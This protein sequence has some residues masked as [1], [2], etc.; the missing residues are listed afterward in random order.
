MDRL[1]EQWLEKSAYVP[2]VAVLFTGVLQVTLG[3]RVAWQNVVFPFRVYVFSESCVFYNSFKLCNKSQNNLP[4]K[5]TVPWALSLYMGQFC[6]PSPSACFLKSTF[7]N[8]APYKL[9]QK[10][11]GWPVV[12]L[13][14][15]GRGWTRSSK[16]PQAV[17]FR[18]IGK[19]DFYLWI[20]S[21]NKKNELF[22][23][24][25]HGP[26]QVL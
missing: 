8:N 9:R 20:Q 25:S 5:P 19:T 11:L 1:A 3:L 24:K 21:L 12:F 26:G 2:T 13:S 7:K 22:S 10:Q 17:V 18:A 16:S 6:A 14:V 15:K 4:Y 23:P